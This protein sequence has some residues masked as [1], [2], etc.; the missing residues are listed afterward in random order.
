MKFAVTGANGYIGRYI[1]KAL[2]DRG[3]S[4]TAVDIAFNDVDSRAER[5]LMSVFDDNKDV[6]EELGKTG[7][8]YPYGM[9]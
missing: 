9:A 6:Y 1:V 8:M 4:V 7:C 3:N 5:I 2:L